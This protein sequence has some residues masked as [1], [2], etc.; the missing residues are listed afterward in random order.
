[1]TTH[2]LRRIEKPWGY[3]DVL[4]ENG[5]GDAAKRVKLLHINPGGRTSLQ[6]HRRKRETIVCTAGAGRIQI[7]EEDQVFMP[8]WSRSI[9]PLTVHRLIADHGQLEV[10]ETSFGDDADIVRLEDAYGRV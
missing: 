2:A 3:E 7:G 5:S 9:P 1:M 10:I 4:W 8:S 6:L